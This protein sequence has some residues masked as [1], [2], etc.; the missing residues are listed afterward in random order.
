MIREILLF[1]KGSFIKCC[2]IAFKLNK[3]YWLWY[4]YLILLRTKEWVHAQSLQSC[5][6]LWDPMDYSLLA[7]SVH[8]ILQVRILEWVAMPSSRGPSQPRDW[9]Q[10]FCISCIAGRFFTA[11]PPGK[12]QEIGC[13]QLNNDTPYI[14]KM[15]SN[16]KDVRIFWS[17]PWNQ[18]IILFSYG[19]SLYK[20]IVQS[21]NQTNVD[22]V[23]CICK[24]KV[25]ICLNFSAAGISFDCLIDA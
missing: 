25:H 18:W 14:V 12:T 5:P 2:I 10:V 7:S 8:G 17:V 21:I 1:T 13:H 15:Y 24:C 6:A 11:E 16:F 9:T 20:V 3:Y 23:S 22:P 4:D 19:N